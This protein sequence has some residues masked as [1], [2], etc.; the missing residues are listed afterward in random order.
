MGKE[1]VRRFRNRRQNPLAEGSSQRARSRGEAFGAS[2]T[3]ASPVPPSGD[4][5]TDRPPA[6]MS[7]VCPVRA[8]VWQ[9]LV[10]LSR[11]T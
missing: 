7:K 2:V 3:Q 8:R 9:R 10:W 11:E 6:V 1:K 4:G 5:P